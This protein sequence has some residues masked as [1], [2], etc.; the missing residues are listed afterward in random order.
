MDCALSTIEVLQDQSLLVPQAG[1][2]VLARIVKITP[3]FAK[4]EILCIGDHILKTSYPGMIRIQDI[5]KTEIDKLKMV[6]C[7]RP[8]DLVR[9]E[10][11]S[12]GDQRSYFLSTAKNELG[13]TFA[14]SAAGGVMVPV[15][16]QEMQC[17][18]TG[19]REMRKVAK[20]E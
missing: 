5:R 15:S 9:A 1:N 2:V 10:V 16:W 8:G 20:M 3:S 19:M 11:I 12:L 6:D 17:T 18:R 4:V 13:V 14:R 7:F